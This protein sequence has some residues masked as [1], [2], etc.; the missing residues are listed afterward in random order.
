MC[1]WQLMVALM[2]KDTKYNCIIDFLLQ[3]VWCTF[4]NCVC[5]HLL[6]IY[7]IYLYLNYCF[8][9]CNCA[10]CYMYLQVIRINLINII[11]GRTKMLIQWDSLVMYRPFLGLVML[12]KKRKMQSRPTWC[13]GQTKK[14][15]KKKDQYNSGEK[16]TRKWE[17]SYNA[18][19]GNRILQGTKTQ[20]ACFYS[21]T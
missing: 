10:L 12:H 17:V 1:V 21:A 9:W 7:F 19:R 20:R 14:K 6:M 13:G 4:V 3:F 2:G 8:H 11:T 18:K 16:V 15:K 5:H